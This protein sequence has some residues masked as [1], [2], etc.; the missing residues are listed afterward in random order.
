MP[1]SA[2]IFISLTV[3][4]LIPSSF[5]F[6]LIPIPLSSQRKA[7]PILFTVVIGLLCV[8]LNTCFHVHL[9][10]RIPWS[11]ESAVVPSA[12]SVSRIRLG[13]Q[14]LYSWRCFAGSINDV[15]NR[16][17][18]IGPGVRN[19]SD[20][21]FGLPAVPRHNGQG[22]VLKTAGVLL[23]CLFLSWVSWF[24]ACPLPSVNSAFLVCTS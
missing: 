7:K 6:I 21:S 11:A 10:V 13:C 8:C 2:Y 16:H 12:G 20:V 1:S 17:C 14:N 3:G 9:Q 5:R 15:L 22:R 4:S 18:T 19:S 23:S 24:P